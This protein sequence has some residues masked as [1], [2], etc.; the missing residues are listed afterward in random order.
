MHECKTGAGRES[1]QPGLDCSTRRVAV[2][3]SLVYDVW[4]QAVFAASQ[5]KGG[6]AEK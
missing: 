2:T 3:A 6:T 5:G 4:M 1:L